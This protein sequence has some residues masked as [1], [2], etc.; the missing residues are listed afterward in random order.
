MYRNIVLKMSFLYAHSLGLFPYKFG[1]GISSI[2]FILF[3]LFFGSVQ[4]AGHLS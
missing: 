4:Q 3:V 1:A 2:L